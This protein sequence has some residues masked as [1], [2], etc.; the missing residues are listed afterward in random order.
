MSSSIQG[1]EEGEWKIEEKKFQSVL[2]TL[3][4]PQ[5]SFPPVFVTLAWPGL[6]PDVVVVAL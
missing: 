6:A 2:G 1:N 3:C 4:A 5:T